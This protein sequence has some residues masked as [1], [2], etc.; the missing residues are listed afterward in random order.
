M[1]L[2]MKYIL[3]LNTHLFSKVTC[4]F[5]CGFLY[6]WL[7]LEG[8]KHS[9]RVLCII[10]LPGTLCQSEIILEWPAY[11]H[12]QCWEA[13][14]WFYLSPHLFV[15]CIYE[16]CVIALCSVSM[17]HD[18]T[19]TDCL[20]IPAVFGKMIVFSTLVALLAICIYVTGPTKI[21]HVSTNYT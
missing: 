10:C 20:V 14:I 18:N 5:C 15:H 16:Q 7:I 19:C 3:A 13:F 4:Q 6:M 2:T 9:K 8:S 12:I 17:V 21:N 1:T 11:C